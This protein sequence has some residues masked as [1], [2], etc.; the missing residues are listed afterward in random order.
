MT[1]ITYTFAADCPITQLRGV[2]VHGGVFC[3][4]TGK[5]NDQTD[6]VRFATLVDGRV[7]KARIAGKPELEQALADH[8]AADAAKVAALAAI[9]W[10]EYQAIQSRAINARGAYDAAS[11]CGY[12]V[13][14][15]RAMKIAD[16]ALDAAR[17]QYPR[18]AAY[19]K[20]ESYSMAAHDQ[21]ASAGN[22]A[23]AAIES[24]EDP[25][26]AVAAMDAV[27]AASAAKCAD[28]N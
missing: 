7:V 27:W 22:K 16:E 2:T 23:M 4:S 12:P 26:V 24:G 10:P 5:Y 15:A 1:T 9:K 19:A 13:K 17:T 8:L 18:A 14:E 11:E 6:V 25:L 28:N 21:K 20:A 3:A